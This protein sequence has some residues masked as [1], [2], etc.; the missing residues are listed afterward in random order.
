MAN[1]NIRKRK[2]IEICNG[3][4]DEEIRKAGSMAFWTREVKQETKMAYFQA[5]IDRD[6]L[7]MDYNTREQVAKALRYM[8]D[9]IENRVPAH[10][11]ETTPKGHCIWLRDTKGDR[12]GW[13]R[14][15]EF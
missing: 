10:E 14:Y 15:E 6:N 4:P 2:R 13:F 11:V 1:I 7:T 5:V 9:H 8:A 3:P 12:I